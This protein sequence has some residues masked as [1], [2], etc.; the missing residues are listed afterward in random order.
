MAIKRTQ[1]PNISF[2][3]T[4][5][6]VLPSHAN[7]IQSLFGGTLVGWIDI[8]A[9]ISA[10]RYSNRICV[11]ASIDTLVFLSPIL[12][13]ETVTIKAKVIHTGTTSMIIEVDVT[14]NSPFERKNR[15][16]V[17]A[18]L[19]MVALDDKRKPTPVP[20]LK[21]RTKAEKK[22]FHF[23]AERRKFLLNQMKR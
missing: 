17:T 21:L 18:Y 7:A 6:M 9:A 23:A 22:A 3:E 19:S 13:G 4:N 15:H 8:A 2:V 12:V 16:C 11:T 14:S 10:Q 5:H 1:S 20:Q